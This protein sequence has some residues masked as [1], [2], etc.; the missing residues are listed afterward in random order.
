MVNKMRNQIEKTL[1]QMGKAIWIT[2][3]EAGSHEFTH[4]CV[5]YFFG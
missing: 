3:W 4:I 5:N 2:S 1:S